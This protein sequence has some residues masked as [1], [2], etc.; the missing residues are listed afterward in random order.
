MA[1][2]DLR[3]CELRT[4]T[5]AS[6]GLGRE[7]SR[8]RHCHVLLGDKWDEREKDIRAWMLEHFLSSQGP[9]HEE[10]DF[11]FLGNLSG[12]PYILHTYSRF[13]TLIP[14]SGILR[15]S[16]PGGHSLRTP[17]GHL[18]TLNISNSGYFKEIKTSFRRERSISTLNMNT[19]STEGSHVRILQVKHDKREHICIW[20]IVDVTG[21]EFMR[22][23]ASGEVQEDAI[24]IAH[25]VT[26]TRTQMGRNIT[27]T[28]SCGA[29]S[30]SSEDQPLED[31][32]H[33]RL[34][35]RQPSLG[36]SPANPRPPSP[37]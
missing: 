17:E 20:K 32:L 3:G 10:I 9:T 29:P 8:D 6:F 33:H 35:C 14:V 15:G 25:K 18:I 2:V 16:S 34:P 21:Y 23:E 4:R 5:P 27:I 7:I 19:S 28:T 12:D 36:R 13:Y 26:T 1:G 11:E 22:V 30:P 37:H 31:H 24:E